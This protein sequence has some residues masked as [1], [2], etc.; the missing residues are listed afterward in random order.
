MG[1][2]HEKGSS[3]AFLSFSFPSFFALL[4]LF[5]P[6]IRLPSFFFNW[7]SS[8]CFSVFSWALV[9]FFPAALLSLSLFPLV[10]R[11]PTSQSIF[12]LIRGGALYSPRD[13]QVLFAEPSEAYV[14]Y[15]PGTR[16]PPSQVGRLGGKAG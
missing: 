10:R 3:F 7:P 16:S 14:G 6:S 8:A 15:V 1:K 12:L 9:L 13:L 11:T 2:I 4:S 5:P